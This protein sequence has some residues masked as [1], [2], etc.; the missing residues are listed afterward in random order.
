ILWWKDRI[1]RRHALLLLP[2]FA[3]GGLGGWMTSR[4]EEIQVGAIGAEWHYTLAQRLLIAGRAVWFYAA[5]LLVPYKLTFVYPKWPVDPTSAAQW[6]NPA[7]AIG[8][9]AVLFLL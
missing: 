1:G 6:I 7:T 9:I 5:K 8:L 4:M 2:F 3:L